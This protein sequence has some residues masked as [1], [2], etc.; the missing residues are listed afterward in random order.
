MKKII[1]LI[2]A[3]VLCTA[4]M[5]STLVTAS[6]EF[7]QTASPKK[8]DTVAIIHTNYGDIAMSFF[9]EYAPK[10]VENFITLAKDGKYD[11]TIF[12]RVKKNF[13]IQ[14]GDYTN[15]DGTGGE[16]CWGEEFENECSDDL[17]NIRGS[18]AYANRGEGTNSSQFFIN[19]TDANS[20]LD[21]SYTVFAQVFAG[22][23]VVDLI[24]ECDVTYNNSGELSQ[25]VN[26]VKVESVEITKY[27][28]GL[29]DSLASPVDPYEGQTTTEEETTVAT[30]EDATEVTTTETTTDNFDFTPIIV[31][32][33]IIVAIGAIVVVY[34]VYDMKQKKKREALKAK[35]YPNK[36]KKK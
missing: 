8:G 24:S 21:G 5:F 11:D 14:G 2:L 6:A 1:S 29:E 19:S 17:S 23:D 7:D 18:V 28:K 22:M 16:S 25:P 33:I 13:V 32:G 12:H 4:M 31:I 30:D 9:D 20:Y 35:K 3:T 26:Q 10:G 15:A 36:K 27:K 34:V